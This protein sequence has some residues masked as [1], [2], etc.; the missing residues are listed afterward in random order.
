MIGSSL[1]SQS[2]T[3]SWLTSIP[4][5]T[6]ISLRSRNVSRKCR[7]QNTTKAMTSL[8]R[9]VQFSTCALRSLNCRPKSGNG[10]AGSRVPSPLAA[11][12]SPQTH[13]TR[14]IPITRQL[15]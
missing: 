12:S 11:P 8:G 10:T 2:L 6:M 1:L 14:S 15:P 5:M 3:A 7:R 13:S 9:Q 4:R